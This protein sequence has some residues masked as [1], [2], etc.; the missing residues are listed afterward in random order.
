MKW[1]G[2]LSL[3]IIAILSL[4]GCWNYKDVNQMIIVSGA[5]ID[6][7]KGKP[8]YHITAEVVRPTEEVGLKGEIYE[9]DG[10]TIFEAIRDLI[11]EASKKPSWAHSKVLL[12]GEEA[13]KK[14]TTPFLDMMY[15]DAEVRRD[16]WLFI[17]EEETAGE[18]LQTD[19]GK[20]GQ[21]RSY[22]IED[23]IKAEDSVT[24]F[25]GVRLWEYIKYQYAEGVSPT[26]P[27]I[28]VVPVGKGKMY[29]VAGTAVFKDD[30][31]VGKL[32]ERE[33]RSYAWIIDEIGG[34]LINV[35]TNIDGEFAEIALEI[36]NSSSK[37]EPFYQDGKLSMRI[38]VEEIIV[39][40]A[41]IDGHTDVI[42]KMNRG[43]LEKDAADLVRQDIKDVVKKVQKEYGSDI[44]GFGRAVK[45]HMPD[46]WKEIRE[47]WD[48]IF[49]IMDVE[50]DVKVKIRGSALHNKPLKA[51]GGI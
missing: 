19:V 23:I 22:Y 18:V 41:E 38:T 39:N 48:K 46:I 37:M 25:H 40:I 13:A 11:I 14:G 32:N 30:K 50:V 7:A 9:S 26:M 5:A 44:F 1:K 35:D 47:D 20:I 34:G 10:Q 27:L 51:G 24:R 33:T 6:S 16:M 45:R 8:G 15:R 43:E 28:R 2:M 49:P 12:I 21:V 29:Q 42:D 3:L 36:F 31:L 17:A 4:T